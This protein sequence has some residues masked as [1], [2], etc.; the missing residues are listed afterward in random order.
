MAKHEQ[1]D[2]LFIEALKKDD[3]F[4]GLVE[5]ASDKNAMKQDTLTL[6][7]YLEKNPQDTQGLDIESIL[8]AMFIFNLLLFYTIDSSGRLIAKFTSIAKSHPDAIAGVLAKILEKWFYSDLADQTDR[9]QD[10]SGLRCVTLKMMLDLSRLKH[11]EDFEQLLKS[12]FAAYFSI[13]P[14]AAGILAYDSLAASIYSACLMPPQSFPQAPQK[15]KKGRYATYSPH[16]KRMIDTFSSIGY[17][18]QM[19]LPSELAKVAYGAS[20]NPETPIE[21]YAKT[22]FFAYDANLLGYYELLTHRML[23]P[24]DPRHLSEIQIQHI[25]FLVLTPFMRNYESAVIIALPLIFTEYFLNALEWVKAIKLSVIR[26]NDLNGFQK[27]EFDINAEAFITGDFLRKDEYRCYFDKKRQFHTAMTEQPDPIQR[28]KAGIHYLMGGARHNYFIIDVQDKPGIKPQDLN[29][30]VQSPFCI[31]HI[32]LFESRMLYFRPNDENP[33]QLLNAR[34][35]NKKN[36]PIVERPDLIPD[37][38]LD[39]MIKDYFFKMR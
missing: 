4:S 36:M 15:T 16:Q 7:Q 39:R 10:P 6:K 22:P 20:E 28:R 2:R 32:R 35:A 30:L 31:G 8:P 38:I 18:E 5:S 13:Y 19:P 23:T 3:A 26:G 34:K 27:I 1:P 14:D 25:Q 37:V 33:L 29:S 11:R 17:S 9:I 12:Q 24:D 21:G